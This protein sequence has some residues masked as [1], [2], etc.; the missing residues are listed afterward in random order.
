MNVVNIYYRL[1]N[2]L[3]MKNRIEHDD[4]SDLEHESD[5][6]NKENE[7]IGNGNSDTNVLFGKD[8][9]TK[10]KIDC[11]RQAVGLAPSILLAICQV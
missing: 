1:S 8:G 5:D 3:L 2:E 11:P 6:S 4:D 9:I 7:E 10:W